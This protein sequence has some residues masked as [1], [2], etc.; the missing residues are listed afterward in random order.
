MNLLRD[1]NILKIS[2]RV[3]REKVQNTW[4]KK[5]KCFTGFSFE[6]DGGGAS[7]F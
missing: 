7:H 6:Y 1:S 5:N 4:V 2:K 3:K